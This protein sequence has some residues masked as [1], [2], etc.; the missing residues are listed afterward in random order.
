MRI[1][2]VNERRITTSE[3]QTVL[4]NIK[5]VSRY[6]AATRQRIGRGLGL[7]RA[8]LSHVLGQLREAGVIVYGDRKTGWRIV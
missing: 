3:Q 8:R 6:G 4:D 5:T 7:D 2:R 1:L